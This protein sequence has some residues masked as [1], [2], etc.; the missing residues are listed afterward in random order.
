LGASNSRSIKISSSLGSV[1]F[2]VPLPV[3]AAIAFLLLLEVF[4]H[5]IQCLEPIGPG[6]LVAHHPLMNRL[7]RRP[8]QSI[9]PL[10]ALGT[11]VNDTNLSEHPQVLR[12]LRLTEPEQP[13]ELADRPLTVDE[14][15][16][17]LSS[18]RFGDRV[19]RV[20]CRR[21]SCHLDALYADMGI[22]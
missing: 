16:E 11:D 22:R 21:C 15:I 14:E 12:D 20:G 1:T 3:A 2:T 5:D 19:E 10:S 6:A 9:E 8:V 17:K 7:Q 4:Q 18:S 13:D